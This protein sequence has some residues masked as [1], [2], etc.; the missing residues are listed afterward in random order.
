MVEGVG[1]LFVHSTIVGCSSNLLLAEKNTFF[2]NAPL[3]LE[4]IPFICHT[5]RQVVVSDT[6]IASLGRMPRGSTGDY[7]V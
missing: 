3:F 1:T 7:Q 6:I 4:N 2:N 5:S